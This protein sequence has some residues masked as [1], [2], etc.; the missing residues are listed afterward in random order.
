MVVLLFGFVDIGERVHL[1]G[2]IGE[3]RQ[4]KEG[5]K[6]GGDVEIV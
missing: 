2:D 6:I 4:K 3:D 5:M 1:R